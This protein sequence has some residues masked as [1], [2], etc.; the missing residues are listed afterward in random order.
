[1]KCEKC[2]KIMKHIE[3]IQGYCFNI[4]SDEVEE[5]TISLYKCECGNEDQKF[6][7]CE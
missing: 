7:E 3:D 1:M 5:G 2:N 4:V 6:K